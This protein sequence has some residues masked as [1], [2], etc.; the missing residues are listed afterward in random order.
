MVSNTC[1]IHQEVIDAYMQLRKKHNASNV[2][3]VCKC[4]KAELLIRL[5]ESYDNITLE[6][7]AEDLSDSSPRYIFYSYK[8]IR[9]DGRVSYP[10]I[11][12]FYSP[13]S[14]HIELNLLYSSSKPNLVT[15]LAVQKTFDVYGT[16][17]LSNEW[18]HNTLEGKRF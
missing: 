7:L 12:I 13:E 15:K 8:W 3:F 10:L 14:V 5:D 18:L 16:D 1:D 11:L 2:A 9:D 4:V 17:D 6:E